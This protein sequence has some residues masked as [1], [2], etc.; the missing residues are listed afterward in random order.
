MNEIPNRSHRNS[1]HRAL[2]L[3]R[4]ERLSHRADRPGDIPGLTVHA[5]LVQDCLETL[6]QLPDESVQLIICDP[7][8]NIQMAKWDS[9]P[10]YRSWSS[11][12][13]KESV[14]VLSPTGSIAIFG[15]LQFQGEA[16]SGDMLTLLHDIREQTPL[17]LVNLIVW[18]YPNGM[19]AHRFFANRHEEIAWFAKS[20]DYTFNL[21]AVRVPF[22]DETK[23]TYLRDKR[24][25][26]ESIAKGKNP[27]NVWTIGRLNGNALERVGHPTQ[28]PLEVL[29]R[30]IAGLSS[31]GDVVL[32]F[33]AGSGSTTAAAIGL[34]RHSIASDTDSQMPGLLSA[35]LKK[36]LKRGQTLLDGPSPRYQLIESSQFKSHPVFL[37]RPTS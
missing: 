33:F 10:A 11:D 29:N 9:N 26:P 31:P 1:G 20:R 24:L 19:S 32:D 36:D 6:R 18:N 13:M 3:I 22:D 5:V 27:S 8:Y 15:G 25:R 35:L 12:W 23:Q 28:K 37:S 21:D 7:P 4:R 30:L 34:G 16:G 17:L 14:R 2:N